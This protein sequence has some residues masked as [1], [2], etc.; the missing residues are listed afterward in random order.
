[1]TFRNEY[2]TLLVDDKE[3]SDDDNNNDG[4]VVESESEEENDDESEKD[5]NPLDAELDD[6]FC[7]DFDEINLPKHHRCAAHQLQLVLKDALTSNKQ[8]KALH[9]VSF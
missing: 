9:N 5:D 6:M 1:M 7:Y 2:E 3:E 4:F 8:L